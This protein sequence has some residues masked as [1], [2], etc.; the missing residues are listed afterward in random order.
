MTTWETIDMQVF[1]RRSLAAFTVMLAMAAVE[2]HAAVPTSTA[3]EGVLTSA[4]GGAAADGS[5]NV[6][7]SIYSAKGATKASWFEGP[8]KVAVKGGRF[9]YP[10]GST[11]A[12]SATALASLGQ[13]WLGIKVGTDPEL[14]RQRMHSAPYALVADRAMKLSCSGCVSGNQLAAGG[15]AASKVGFTYAGSTTKGGPASNLACTGC[16]SVKELKFDNNV[17]LGAYSLKAKNATFTGEV[18]A[19]KV[20]ATSFSGDGSKLTGIKTPSGECKVAGEVVK[21]INA[22]GSL[23]C[24]KAVAPSALPKDGLNEISNDLIS[25]QFQD[26]I[27]TSQ[28]M[29]AIPDNQGSEAVSNLTFPDIGVAQQ[30]SMY[31]HIENTDLSKIAVTVLPPNDKKTGWTLCDPCGTKD[32]KIYKKT[33][34]PSAKPKSGNIGTWIGKNPKGLWNLKVKDT[35]FCVPQAPGNGKYCNPTKKTDGWIATWNIKIQT[36]SNKKIA[37]KGN[38]YSTGGLKLGSTTTCNTVNKGMIRWTDGVGLQACNGTIWVSKTTEP[39]IFQGYCSNSRRYSST[40]NY[41]CLNKQD[42]NTASSHFTVSTYAP[43]GGTS[44]STTYDKYWHTNSYKSGRVTFKVAG[45]YRV[46]FKLRQRPYTVGG[47]RIL[48]N[49][50]TVSYAYETKSAYHFNTLMNNRILYLK[51]GQYLEFVGYTNTDNGTAYAILAD[52]THSYVNIEFL[53]ENM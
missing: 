16:V 31:V 7:F 28:K 5:Y 49:G 11:K 10:L 4:G 37:V 22:D 44:S 46:V 13:A 32:S 2:A 43:P 35:S 8:V 21:G 9:S 12:L 6:T 39:I 27:E 17:D 30:F 36:L 3:V 14:P 40:W 51:A 50:S 26:T 15:V 19:G 41:Y 45:Y 1:Q 47:A 18:S 48:L 52:A 53:G 24:V 38:T 34:T 20:V 42:I 23:K 29:V 33:F 25:N